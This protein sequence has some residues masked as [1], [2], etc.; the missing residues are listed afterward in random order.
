MAVMPCT[1]K[2]RAVPHLSD[3]SDS[4]GTIVSL[5]SMKQKVTMAVCKAEQVGTIVN[6]VAET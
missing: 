6:A 4:S 2:Q 3:S 1:V 5:H